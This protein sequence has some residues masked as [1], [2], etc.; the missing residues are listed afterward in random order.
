MSGERDAAPRP[1][2][3]ELDPRTHLVTVVAAGAAG[4]AVTGFGGTVLLQVFSAGYLAVCGRVRTAGRSLLWFA[5]VAALSFAPLPGLWG[6]LLV[7]MLHMMPACTVGAAF[8]LESPSAIMCALGRWRLPPQV[9]IG[10]CM[11]FRF[12][13]VLRVEIA[14]IARGIRMRGIFPRALDILLHPGTAY[15]CAYT[16]LVM[17]CLRLS[18]ELAAS[19][20]L[21]GIDAGCPRTSVHHVGLRACDAAAAVVYALACLLL[22]LGGGA[23]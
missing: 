7:S 6:V 13:S 21:R 23:L 3:M 2:H 4:V 12:V 17:R 20:E 22:A 8:Y 19:A 15:E 1:R 11:L 9:L 10:V 18:S 16:P 14:S 5:A